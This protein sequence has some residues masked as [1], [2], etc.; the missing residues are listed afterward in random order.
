MKTEKSMSWYHH[1]VFV[2]VCFTPTHPIWV[3][4]E[5]RRI[6]MIEFAVLKFFK[7]REEKKKVNH[8]FFSN[9]P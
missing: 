8:N 3:E 6:V 4:Y 7:I 2:Y 1:C 9:F 5:K